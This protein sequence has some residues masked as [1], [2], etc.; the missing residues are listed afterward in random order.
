M[1]N[2]KVQQLT[3]EEEDLLLHPFS[4]LD[5]EDGASAIDIDDST[6]EISVASSNFSNS[7]RRSRVSN[8]RRTINRLGKLDWNQMSEEDRMRL[9]NA[10]AFMDREGLGK[11]SLAPNPP[12]SK[13]TSKK[14]VMGPPAPLVPKQGKGVIPSTS[15]AIASIADERT[16]RKGKT[17]PVVRTH[18]VASNNSSAKSVLSPAGT[19]DQAG[20]KGTTV[21]GKDKGGCKDNLVGRSLQVIQKTNKESETANHTIR[22]QMDLIVRTNDVVHNIPSDESVL[23]PGGTTGLAGDKDN[24]VEGKDEMGCKDNLVGRSPQDIQ[25]TTTDSEPAD[26]TM[27]TTFKH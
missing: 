20:G 18:V 3:E 5:M 24:T 21:E 27:N 19:I 23:S 15:S 11:A 6:S 16:S 2:N 10:R 1:N 22:N 13:G 25:N 17:D 14:T 26:R 7:S 4:N 8:C 9:H 12:S